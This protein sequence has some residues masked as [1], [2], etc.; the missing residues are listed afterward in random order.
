[1]SHGEDEFEWDEAAYLARHAKKDN[2]YP[3]APDFVEDVEP[4]DWDDPGPSKPPVPVYR[5]G[6]IVYITHDGSTVIRTD[7]L[8]DVAQAV[9]TEE[10]IRRAARDVYDFHQTRRV[11]ESVIARMAR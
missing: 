10:D 3:E 11:A 6:F 4:E 1:M 2:P 9:P 5:C 8:L 7:G